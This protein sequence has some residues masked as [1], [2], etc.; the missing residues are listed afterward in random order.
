MKLVA[1]TLLAIAGMA[2]AADWNGAVPASVITDPARDAAHPASSSELLI[3]SNGSELNALIYRA[4]G[5]GP[6]PT[7]VL[8]HGIPGNEQNLD[9]AQAIRRAGWNVLTLHYRGSWG[10][11]G[12]FS[13]T[14]SIE[15]GDAVLAYVRQPEVAA[16]FGIDRDRLVMGGHSMGGLVT[17][18]HTRHDPALLGS[19]L[20]DAWNAGALGTRLA[21]FGKDALHNEAEKHFDDFGHSLQGAD[22]DSTAAELIAHKDDWNY[23]NWAPQLTGRPLLV[24]GAAHSGGEQNHALAAAVAKA[25]GKVQ[26]YTL[27]S[28]HSFQDH[29]IALESIIVTW[30]NGLAR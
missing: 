30:L 2:Q 1:L 28:D 6:H 29:R 3:P 22:P 24:I 17:A 27:D 26:D 11:Q 16:K 18:A 19:F 21:A 20:I 8:L 23:V 15:D 9:L 13:V 5:A 12:T 25:G 7:V 14:H 10:S 4:A